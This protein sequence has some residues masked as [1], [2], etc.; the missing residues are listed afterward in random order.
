MQIRSLPQQIIYGGSFNPVH[1]GH[2]GFIRVLLETYPGG[3]ILVVPARIS[4]FKEQSALLPW[5]LRLRMLRAATSGLSRVAILDTEMRMTPPSY[6]IHTINRLLQKFPRGRITWAMGSDVYENLSAWLHPGE[7]LARVD[8]L[9]VTR[10]GH[11]YESRGGEKSLLSYLPPNWRSR[12]ELDGP[13]IV[14]SETGRTVV[15]QL[16]LSLPE[17]SSSE[18]ISDQNLESTPPGARELLAEYWQSGQSQ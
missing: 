10:V 1:I 4:P 8:L 18:L 14:D 17:V 15:R 6:T 16:E 7:I 13:C 2:T 12:C 3:H 5:T 9:I 11:Q